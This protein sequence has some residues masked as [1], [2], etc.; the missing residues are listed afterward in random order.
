MTGTFN[1]Q[2]ISTLVKEEISYQINTQPPLPMVTE[3]HRQMLHET[4]VNEGVAS[5]VAKGLGAFGGGKLGGIVGGVAGG[6]IGSLIGTLIGMGMGGPLGAVVGFKFGSV[7]G[8]SAG[9]LTG[10]VKGGMEGYRFIRRYVDGEH[11]KAAAELV[12]VTTA[13]DEAMVELAEQPNNPKFK[14]DVDRLT[15][16]QKKAGRELSRTIEFSIS[17]GIID[18]NE[19]RSLSNI[20]DKA[21]EGKLTYLTKK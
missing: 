3:Q 8:G 15:D 16:E 1:K 7:I 17:R 21:M 13:R 12:K 19:Y 5:A 18:R 14:S 10:I 9:A 2:K 4:M 20:S 6:G 11:G